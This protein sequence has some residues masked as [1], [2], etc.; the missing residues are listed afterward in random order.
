M[1]ACGALSGCGKCS[2]EPGYQGKSWR[3]S[4][5]LRRGGETALPVSVLSA[6]PSAICLNAS[7]WLNNLRIWGISLN[8]RMLLLHHLWHWRDLSQ[9]AVEMLKTC[10]PSQK[11]AKSPG[12]ACH[13][14]KQEHVTVP[15]G[16]GPWERWHG[17]LQKQRG[18]ASSILR[19]LLGT[20][21][22]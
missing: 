3:K 9:N 4:Q 21:I 11:A 12:E 20:E 15:R 13:G 16:D 1:G 17:T 14:I 5:T 7:F 8:F 6:K 19:Q 22:R 10:F 18:L 2:R